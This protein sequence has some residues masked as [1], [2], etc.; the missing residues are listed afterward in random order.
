MSDAL[1]THLLGDVRT[2]IEASRYRAAVAVNSEVVLL[3]WQIGARVRVEILNEARAE[4]GAKIIATLSRQLTADY[5]RGF[6]RSNLHRMVQF[7]EV[8]PDEEIVAALRRQLTWTHLRELIAIDDPLKRQFYTEMCRIERWNTRTLTAKINGMLFERTA[9]ARRP[10]AVITR[11]LDALRDSD[12]L[13][14]DLVFRDPYVLDFLG[15]N[16]EHSE[17][18]LEAAILRD[19]ENF[20]LELGAGFSFVARQKRMQIGPDDYYLDLLF[21][22]RPLRA[23]V[24]IELKLGRF[25]ARDKGQM[26]LYL[27]WLNKH[28]R[29]PDE[30][31][32]LGL[33]LCAD[34]NQE[35]VELL[36]L[37]DGS[38]RVA[39][40]LTALPPKEL[41]ERKLL[42]SVERAKERV[43]PAGRPGD[44]EA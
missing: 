33:I 2:L 20:L 40:Y 36:E 30:N 3:Y 32:P 25:D 15:L 37:E 23:L 31:Q 41:L 38:L 18:E 24:A 39:S 27:R 35:Q 7:A 19:L 12:R 22:H 5:G 11:D 10:E 13:T 26:E 28:E 42:S 14:P 34:R 17:G 16:P 43:G 4:Y 44:H 8:F 1:P 9:I 6:T 21:F 29:Q